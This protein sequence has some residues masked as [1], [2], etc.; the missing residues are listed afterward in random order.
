MKAGALLDGAT[1][2]DLM[3]CLFDLNELE[4]RLYKELLKRGP[5]RPQEL[6]KPVGRDRSTVYRCL[7]K[8]VTCGIATKETKALEKGG[9]FYVYSAVGK[10]DLK[11]RLEECAKR[12]NGSMRDAISRIDE[13]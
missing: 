11:K 5:S 9:Y 2:S 12:V 1:C 13:L 8:L 3:Q 4:L 7:E 6:A 10:G